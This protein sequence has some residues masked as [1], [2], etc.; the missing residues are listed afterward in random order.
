MAK[1]VSPRHPRDGIKRRDYVSSKIDHMR[2][3]GVVTITKTF[4]GYGLFGGA[5]PNWLHELLDDE[6]KRSAAYR[7]RRLIAR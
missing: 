3:I 6:D 5:C 7:L 2:R 1:Q 4:I